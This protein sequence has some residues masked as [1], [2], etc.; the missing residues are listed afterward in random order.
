MRPSLLFQRVNYSFESFSSYIAALRHSAKRHLGE[1]Q[2]HDSRNGD[3]I[4]RADT[5]RY[6]ANCR[7]FVLLQFLL[8]C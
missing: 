1:R 3:S 8:L 6:Y 7:L 5:G 2:K 4:L